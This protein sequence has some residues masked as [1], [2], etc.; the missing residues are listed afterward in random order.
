M[1]EQYRM[2]GRERQADLERD[3]L[4]LARGNRFKRDRMTRR[5]LFDRV[6]SIFSRSGGEVA[7]GAQ[8]P[9]SVSASHE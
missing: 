7:A 6:V 4:R 8:R 3:A 2:L 5:A 1:H 9:S